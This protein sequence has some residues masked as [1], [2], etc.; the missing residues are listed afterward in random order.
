M[1]NVL[2]VIAP[3]NFRDEELLEP[4]QVLVNSG[5]NVT[6]ASKGTT[7]AKGSCGASVKVDMSIS[8]VNAANYDAV[9]FV[10]GSGATV[11]LNDATAHSIAKHALAAGKILAAICMAPSIL[12]NAGLLKGKRATCTPSE[13]SNLTSNGAIVEDKN[14]VQDGNIITGKGPQAARE[15][16]EKI[17][18]S[19]K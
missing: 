16:G 19:L 11:Y 14:V 13:V 18:D 15:F 3:V 7:L 4:K 2:M 8:Q 10:G 12:A 17:R 9:V 5:A 1:K 6:I